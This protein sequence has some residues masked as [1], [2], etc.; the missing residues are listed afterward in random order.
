[1]KEIYF[2]Q[3][4]RLFNAF[5]V[6]FLGIFLSFFFFDLNIV[7]ADYCSSQSCTSFGNL[8]CS[9]QGEK[10]EVQHAYGGGEFSCVQTCVPRGGGR[11]CPWGYHFDKTVCVRKCRDGSETCRF[12]ARGKYVC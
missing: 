9:R 12:N 4:G 11:F 5:L 1:M 7:N 3:R 8:N 6:I 10:C 2:M